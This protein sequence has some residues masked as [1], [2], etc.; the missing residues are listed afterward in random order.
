MA[1]LTRHTKTT[2]DT[3]GCQFRYTVTSAP[4][5]DRWTRAGRVAQVRE[6]HYYAMGITCRSLDELRRK[7]GERP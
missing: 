5:G 2:T 3:R 7:V 4:A 1:K 6:R